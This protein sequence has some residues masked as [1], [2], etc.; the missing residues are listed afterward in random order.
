MWVGSERNDTTGLY[1]WDGL[2]TH[3]IPLHGSVESDWEEVPGGKNCIY[4]KYNIK[5]DDGMCTAKYH[6][7]CE[8]HFS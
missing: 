7:V 3:A 2:L 1:Y 5:W 8:R 4:V 6:V